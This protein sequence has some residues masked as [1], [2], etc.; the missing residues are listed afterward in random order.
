MAITF[1]STD[2]TY[3]NAAGADVVVTAPAS[4]QDDDLLVYLATA[5]ASTMSETWA[6]PSGFTELDSHNETAGRNHSPAIGWKKASSESGDYTFTLTSS[7]GDNRVAGIIVLRGVDTGTPIDVT[8]VQGTHHST[9]EDDI[10]PPNAAI[11]TVTDGAWVIVASALSHSGFTGVAPTSY[12]L[13]L[14]ESN[15]N[16]N[17]YLATR[18]ITSFGVE[19]PGDWAHTDGES[20][21]EYCTFTIAIRPAAAAAGKPAMYYQN[22]QRRRAV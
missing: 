1:V 6:T 3:T 12:D 22:N 11:T 2:S 19:S 9:G 13:R 8:Y 15:V 20:G 17:A 16:A 18:E 5:A 14:D 7:S 21:A 4:I 10:T